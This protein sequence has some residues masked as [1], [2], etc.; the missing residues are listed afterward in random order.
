[1]KKPYIGILVSVLVFA[2]FSGIPG[3]AG[4]GSAASPRDTLFSSPQVT[5]KA[6]IKAFPFPLTR[7]R[8]LA[9]P[10]RDAQELNRRYLLSLDE[11]RLLHC[12]LLTAGRPSSTSPYGG[13]EELEKAH[14]DE[15]RG[16]SLGHYLS[17]CA[18]MYAA[19]GDPGL[20]AKAD[21]IVAEL[22]E[23]QDALGDRG[24][25]SAFPEEHFDRVES[26]RKVWAPYYTIHKII[27]GLLDWHEYGRNARSLE[28]AEKMAGWI[29][30]RT[31]RSDERHMQRV[32]ES[33][34]QGGM[35]EVLANL[36]SLTGK[37]EHLTLARRFEEQRN[38]IPLLNH[39]D[40]LK[41]K[42]VNSFIPQIIGTA[43]V[44]ELTGERGLHTIASFFWNQVTRARIFATGGMSNHERWG[45]DP[46][47][48]APELGTNNNESCCTYN[49]LKLSRQLFCWGASPE[50]ADYYE[51]AL[52]NGMLST[53]NPVDGMTMY[54]QAMRSGFYKTYQSPENSFWCC[55][56]S[57][58]ESHAKYGDSIYFHDDAG[59]YVNLF[60]ASELDWREKGVKVRQETR[61][62][63][64]QGTTL[65]I[66]TQKPTEFALRIRIP[67][68][69]APGGGI[70]LN[71]RRIEAFAGP[72]S[73]LILKR[74]WKTGD[75]IEVSL[76]MSLRLERL[77]DDPQ[78][79]AVFFGPTLLAG[80]LGRE[81]LTEEMV[82]NQ[83]A[84]TGDPVAVPTFSVA[85]DDP[86]TWIEPSGSGPLSFRTVG[87]G[88]P[89]DVTLIPFYRLYDQR[90]AVYWKIEPR[91]SSPET[92]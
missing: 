69:V 47:V 7:I 83:Y 54:H 34:E 21:A 35:V 46:Y 92:Q 27:A 82:V 4:P 22:G 75:R 30:L 20:K 1:M 16:H 33:T 73:Y 23:C 71:G 48:L 76:P 79:A 19:T 11:D 37:P 25:L 62:P 67:S 31:D 66:S 8:L 36:Y 89:H 55:T 52:L 28:I 18:L 6:D 63:E 26:M 80:E 10:F 40:Q 88:R 58:M 56:G 61:F 29:K 42:H 24:Y 57:G 53:Q 32:L 12:F 5:L 84:P 44:Y 43:R 15:L 45:N 51:R 13:W 2:I 77:P 74:V 91:V 86:N 78:T 59:L 70:R 72:G 17:A 65:L 68:W 50:V 49:M 14:N 3:A 41:G 87:V 39:Q 81:G 64:E 9:G 85:H 60:I 38:L 90:Y